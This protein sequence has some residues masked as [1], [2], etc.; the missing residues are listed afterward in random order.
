MPGLCF[1]SRLNM[2]ADIRTISTIAEPYGVKIERN[3]KGYNYEVSVHASKYA[4]A[5]E[6]AIRMKSRIEEALGM[7]CKPKD[8]SEKL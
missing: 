6:E 2:T 8:L 1:W 5:M 3:S 4:D 7:E